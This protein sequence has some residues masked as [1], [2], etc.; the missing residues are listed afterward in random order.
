MRRPFVEFG[1]AAGL[2]LLLTIAITWPLALHMG[3]RVPNDLGDSLLNMFLLAWNAREMPLT[4]QWWNLPQFYPIP[5]VMAFSEHLLGLSVITTPI[6]A[7]TG[8]TVLAYNAAFLLSFPLCAFAA[9]LLCFELTRRHDLSLVAGLAYGFAPYRMSQLAH[10]QVLSAYWMPLALLCLHLFMRTRRWWWAALFAVSWL[11]QAL[12]C[13]YYLFYLS[14]LVGLWLLW[15]AVSRLR[16]TEL[17]TILLA[18]GAAL[19]ALVPVARG[20]LTY[21]RAYGFQR[22]PDEIEAFSG[23]VASLLTAPGNLRV[24]GWLRFV[25]RPESE[26]FPGLGLAVLIV[27]GAAVAWT[28]AARGGIERLRA[29]RILLAAA[30]VV[31]CVAATPLWFGPWKLEIGGT[32]LLSVGSPQKPLSVAVFLGVLALAMHPSIRV[33][34]RLRSPLAFYTLAA[35]VMWL[36]SLGPSPTLM[37][38]PLLYKAPYSW[39]M[40]LP[41]V[42]GVRVPAR[43][44]VLATMCLAIAGA[45]ALGHVVRKWPRARRYLPSALA[46]LLLVESWPQTLQLEPVPAPRPAHTRTMARLDLPFSFGHDLAV[47]YRAIEHRRPVI[48]G[49][50]GYFAPHYRALQHLLDRHDPAVLTYLR[51]LGSIEVVVDNDHDRRGRWRAY[52]AAQPHAEIVHE[53]EAYTAYRLGR[54]SPHDGLPSFSAPP[55][56]IA[57]ISAST[58]QDRVSNMIDGDRITRWD[59]AGPQ[60]PTDEVL[61]DLGETR[62]LEG[63]EMQIA[64]YVA[65]FPRQLVIDVSDDRATWHPQ[66]SGST[67]LLAMV[68]ALEAPLSVPLRFRFDDVRARYIRLRQASRDP[69]YYWSIAELRV[70]GT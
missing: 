43:F 67:G 2:Y 22:W 63:L 57:A 30:A 37:N 60:G 3:S 41:G 69:I 45:L 5:G 61:L 28:A 34:W 31:A 8:N 32:R 62:R 44:W 35:A 21:Q 17:A 50:S 16:W 1:V 39:L 68:A 38:E 65:D 36:F 18:W 33:G 66:W 11:M 13:G 24:W 52:I 25:V 7:A 6:I 51:S 64:G 9:H 12:A 10:L 40:L 46:I 53:E 47:L 49:Y 4:E 23:D 58:L 54:L 19:L 70:H 48:N 26:F 56:T 42:D 27:T 55:L 20:Y 15:F 29:P 14:V 59:T